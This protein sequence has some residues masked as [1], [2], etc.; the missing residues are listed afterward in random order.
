M[1]EIKSILVPIDGSDHASRA[2]ER[3]IYLAEKC[4]AKLVLLSVV[5]LNLQFS[6]YG[7]SLK[8]TTEYI[9]N[10]V[11]KDNQEILDKAIRMI[12]DGIEKE[13]YLEIGAP[14]RTIVDFQKEH[15]CDLIVM[16][17]HGLGMIGQVV[18]GSVSHSVLYYADCPVLIT[19]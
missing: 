14:S 18:L 11:K 1:K 10:D 6:V 7:Q 4:D 17:S 9:P 19:K 5:D 2:L 8:M 13:S 15:N 16:G 12:P 3:A